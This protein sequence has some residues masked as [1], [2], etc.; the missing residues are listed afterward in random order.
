MERLDFRSEAQPFRGY[1]RCSACAM[2]SEHPHDNAVVCKRYIDTTG[3]GYQGHLVVTPS[4]N[5]PSFKSK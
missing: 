4:F 5:C 1:A 2:G 3:K